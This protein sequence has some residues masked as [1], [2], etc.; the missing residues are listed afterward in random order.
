MATKIYSGWHVAP[1]AI[2]ARSRPQANNISGIPSVG[3][4]WY[5]SSLSMVYHDD[6]VRS[7]FFFG[8]MGWY[9]LTLLTGYS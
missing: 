1:H 8:G 9:L 5:V 2:D 4:R 6:M 7:T 3:M